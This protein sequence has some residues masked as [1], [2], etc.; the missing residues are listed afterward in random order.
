MY[1]YF[2]AVTSEFVPSS[3]TR[4]HRYT[5]LAKTTGRVGAGARQTE[6]K[7]EEGWRGDGDV[8]A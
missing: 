6:R 1:L 3:A 2:V 4:D 8:K 7:T 5:S